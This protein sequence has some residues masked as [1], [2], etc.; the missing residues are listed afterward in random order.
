M[1]A[2]PPTIG[3]L[4]RK[5][6]A[7]HRGLAAGAALALFG[8]IGGTTAAVV[9]ALRADRSAEEASR[10]AEQ[11]RVAAEEA[12]TSE[13]QARISEERANAEALTNAQV[14]EFVQQL[15]AAATPNV[16]DGEEV[17]VRQV[18]EAGRE[19]LVDE[20]PT[21][22]WVGARVRAFF[23]ATLS[24]I[25]DYS[26]AAPYVEQALPVL[27][28]FDGEDDARLIDLRATL[29][30]CAL[31]VV[32]GDRALEIWTRLAGPRVKRPRRCT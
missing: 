28:D 1:V 21:D 26:A 18:L 11:A 22:S 8:L 25:G 24:A 14:V 13:Q 12:L 20:L 19:G 27:A 6:V 2:R 31:G 30:E 23:G 7:R 15:F 16:A 10:A 4:S 3:Y 9:W 29:R 17:T 5:F 32:V